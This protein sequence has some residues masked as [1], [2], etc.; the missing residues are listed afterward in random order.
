MLLNIL[1]L[2]ISIAVVLWGADRFT[3]AASGMARRFGVTE[4]VIGLSVVALGTSLPEFVVSLF[5]AIRGSADMSV[6]NI[7]G[8]NIF[9]TLVILGASAMMMP[10]V[11]TKRT[12]HF[13]MMCSLLAGILLLVVCHDMILDSWEAFGLLM[14]FVMYMGYTYFAAL[15]GKQSETGVE[16]AINVEQLSWY[17][18]I[19]YFL[20]GMACLVGGGQVLVNSASAIATSFGMSERMVGLT[21]LAAGTSF[22][23]LATSV[24]AA[25][26][27]SEGLAIGNAVGSNIFNIMFVLGVVPIVSPLHI[28]GIS[29]VDWTALIG[30]GVLLIL[31]SR[32]RM[33]LSKPEGV[34]LVMA[35]VVYLS[36]IIVS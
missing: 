33:R 25:R 17:R 26:K 20:L 14:V 29:T 15:K 34:L 6:G 19:V 36:W 9:N 5:S 16:H 22:P 27:G 2:I 10:M 23:E 1:L 21:I 32:I 7:V 28:D 3:D 31:L 24:I 12:L 4:M 11:V 8:S 13:D 35:Y 30:S 18:I